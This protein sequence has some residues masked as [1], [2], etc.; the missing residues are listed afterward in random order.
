[1]LSGHLYHIR[2]VT[3]KYQEKANSRGYKRFQKTFQAHLLNFTFVRLSVALND[4]EISHPMLQLPQK[5]VKPMRNYCRDLD[6]CGRTVKGY[7]P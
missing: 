6:I 1:M 2:V 3:A 7:N 5:S 4:N